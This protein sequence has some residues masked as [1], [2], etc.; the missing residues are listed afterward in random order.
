MNLKRLLIDRIE[1]RVL[2]GI[3]IFLATMVLVGWVAINEPGRMASFDQVY[4]AR[5]TEHVAR[6]A[7]MRVKIQRRDAKSFCGLVMP[8]PQSK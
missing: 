4:M 8:A 1:N 7:E 6:I 3:T 5:S 2:I